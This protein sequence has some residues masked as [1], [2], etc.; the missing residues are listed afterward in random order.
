M[1]ERPRVLIA[2]AVALNGGD[3]A[4]LLAIREH[5]RRI[6]DGEPELV[7]AD[8]QGEVADRIYDGME[9]V[10]PLAAGVARA[11]R[12]RG[13][14]RLV[15]ALNE[16]RWLAAARA[17]RR[18]PWLSDRL[19]RPHERRKLRQYAS[20]DLAVSTGGTYLVEHYQI[21][22]RLLELRVIAALGVPLVLYTQSLGPFE[23]PR[24]RRLV[25]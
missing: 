19:L 14:G 1:R 10:K 2:N 20:L 22:P 23:Q 6:C 13:L 21:W 3:G 17:L 24:N 8:R 15:R 4:I 11:P 9:F 12:T 5:L 16:R 7:V 18:A 25:P